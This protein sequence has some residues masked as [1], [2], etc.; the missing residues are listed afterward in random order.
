VASVNTREEQEGD[1]WSFL[2]GLTNSGFRPT[3]MSV[4]MLYLHR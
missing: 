2:E 3:V 4:D 1:A